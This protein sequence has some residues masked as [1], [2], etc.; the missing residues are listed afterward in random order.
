MAGELAKL[1]PADVTVSPPGQRSGQVERMLAG[2]ELNLG[3][4]S[5][6]S[7]L[8]GMFLIY[9]TIAASVV[10]RRVETGILRA[11]G[12]SRA[13]VQALFLGEAVLFGFFG[14]VLGIIGGVF[15]A[16]FLL[17]REIARVIS[18][19]YL[20]VSVERYFLTPLLVGSA[21]FFGLGSVLVAAWLPARE[22][23]RA[24]PVAALSLGLGLTMERSRLHAPRWLLAGLATLLVAV[25]CAVLSLTSG[26]A[27]LGFGSAFFV[28]LGF[29]FTVPT[30]IAGV[31]AAF[32][33]AVAS[34]D[35]RAARAEG[36]GRAA[37]AILLRRAAQNLHR[38]LHRTA[39]IVAALMAAVAM[40]VGISVM[41]HAFRRT[42]EVWIDRAIVADIFMTPA[43][44]ET[45]GNGAF[46][47]PEVLAALR[48]EPA[49][50]KVDTVREVGVSVR[51]DRVSMAVVEGDNENKL[52]FV[53]GGAAEKQTAFYKPDAVFVS[54]PFAHRY[55]VTAGDRLPIATPD[56]PVEF[57]VVGVYYDY[58]RD[59]GIVAISRE[60]FIRHWHDERVM[61]AAIYLK[62]QTDLDATADGI[63]AR[64]NRQGEF[65]IFSNRAIREKVFEIFNQTFRVTGVLRGIAVVVAVI[66]IF[67]TLT[68]L[69]TEREKEIGV[70][71]AL[72]ASRPQV[73]GIVLVES[74]LIGTLASLLGI[75]AGLALSLVLTYV[76][77]KAFFG[78][79][80]Q[81]SV[82][83]LT[84]LATPAWIIVASLVAGWLPALRAG[85]VPIAASIRSE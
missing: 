80:I 49:V 56:G 28:L 37:C 79:T 63:R 82:P 25:L 61:S 84:V 48:R 54:E 41:I 39:V 14:V 53:G 81:F 26:P 1:V 18:T 62:D 55:H 65:L 68:T 3:A 77:N 10:R 64:F 27:W 73:Q 32:R 12:A 59:S 24:D 42:V 40:T 5:L 30:L 50:R 45:L 47:P 74:A 70:L 76:I 21:F 20:L 31:S 17:G 52:A 72:G 7:L 2:F 83:W 22:G 75:V 11:L 4:L 78:W 34:G 66:G 29:A 6:I 44:N 35:G 38:S 69:I 43:A 15:L 8:G 33:R 51:G 16:R 85:R 23:A 57:A 9:N 13:E 71:R 46:F 67:L 36:G 19:L 58:S 60:N